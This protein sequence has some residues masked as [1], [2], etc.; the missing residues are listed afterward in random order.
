MFLHVFVE[1]YFIICERVL[2]SRLPFSA[3]IFFNFHG[4]LLHEITDLTNISENKTKHYKCINI[5]CANEVSG[6]SFWLNY[7]MPIWNLLL[8]VDSV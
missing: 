6:K 3:N 7:C 4:K 1:P 2:E 5:F 8:G